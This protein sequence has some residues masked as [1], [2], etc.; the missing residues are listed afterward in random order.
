M[1]ESFMPR[2]ATR[3]MGRERAVRENLLFRRA[4][5][6][7]RRIAAGPAGG[8]ARSGFQIAGADAKPHRRRAMTGAIKALGLGQ[9]RAPVGHV[10][11]PGFDDP[12]HDR[13]MILDACGSR[14]PAFAP[15]NTASRDKTT[16]RCCM[17][18]RA[19]AMGSRKHRR[20]H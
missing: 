9:Q 2:T 8:I 15:K 18:V 14:P 1:T 17:L 19:P 13:Q 16:A 3:R 7:R 6:L 20:Q 4:L 5:R 12:R 11:V 10:L